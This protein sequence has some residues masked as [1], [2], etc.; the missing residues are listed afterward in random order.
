MLIK[1]VFRRSLTTSLLVFACGAASVAG[2]QTLVNAPQSAPSP[3]QP[4][5]PLVI[6]PED[7]APAPAAKNT[8]LYCGGFIQYAPAPNN[9]EIVGGEEEQEQHTYGQG[10]IVFINAGSQ[11][12]VKVG[13]EFTVIR[14][15][16]QFST[17][18]TRKKG[19]LGVYTQELGV[20]RVTDVK[21]RVSVAQVITSCETMLLGDLLRPAPLRAARPQ[22][23]EAQLDRFRDPSGKQTGR[24]V[25]ARDGREAVAPNEIVYIDLGT[26]D[27]IKPGDYFTVFRPAGTGN[28]TRFRDEEIVTVATGGFE[29]DRFKG[30]KFSNQAQRVKDPNN[31]GIYGPTVSTPDVKSRRPP[32]P[33]KVVGEL[34]ILGVQQRTATAVITRVA[35]EVHTGDFVELQ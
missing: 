22:R 31:N 20:L 32:V 19:Y 27:N 18:L 34:V 26:E 28:I 17:K 23:A 6:L 7:K 21:N 9:M 8:E 15:H 29:S 13:Q 11:A 5:R 30:G 12:G 2:A 25:L 33:R 10:D 24:L 14:P 16:G 1:N 3:P 35:Q 4:P